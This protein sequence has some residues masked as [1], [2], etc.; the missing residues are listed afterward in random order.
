MSN[1]PHRCADTYY[2]EKQTIDIELINCS[3]PL[4]IHSSNLKLDIAMS[5]VIIEIDSFARRDC[6]RQLWNSPVILMT[7]IV[8]RVSNWPLLCSG[9]AAMLC[10]RRGF[11]CIQNIPTLRKCTVDE[12]HAFKHNSVL[13]LAKR[14]PSLISAKAHVAHRTIQRLTSCK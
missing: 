2:R 3:P 10:M 5:V 9:P 4:S 11:L 8:N 12:I 14:K 6:H 7:S 13:Y 1:I